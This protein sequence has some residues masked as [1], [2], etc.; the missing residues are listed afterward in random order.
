MIRFVSSFVQ[1]KSYFLPQGN[2]DGLG[3]NDGSYVSTH[4]GYSSMYKGLQIE[5][6]PSSSA[7][8]K[9]RVYFWEITIADVAK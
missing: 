6:T 3:I 1:L 9:G 8:G 4:G 7:G 2:I 5:K